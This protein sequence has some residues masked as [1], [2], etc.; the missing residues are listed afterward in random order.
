MEENL[1]EIEKGMLTSI[2][3]GIKIMRVD[4]SGMKAEME[5]MREEMKENEEERKRK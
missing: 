1:K 4:L 5:D 2:L 3:E